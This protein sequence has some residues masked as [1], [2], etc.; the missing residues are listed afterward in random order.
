M[1][2]KFRQV[3]F[4]ELFYNRDYR[5]IAEID[6]DVSMIAEKFGV[7]FVDTDEYSEGNTKIGYFVTQNGT[8]FL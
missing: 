6:V 4:R 3:E 1:P 8:P 2:L 7:T 5:A